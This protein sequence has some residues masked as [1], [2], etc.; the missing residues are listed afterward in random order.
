MLGTSWTRHPVR[1]F[2]KRHTPPTSPQ[3]AATVN[4][5]PRNRVRR[6]TILEKPIG[7]ISAPSLSHDRSSRLYKNFDRSKCL[8]SPPSPREG[9]GPG[10]TKRGLRPENLGHV[11]CAHEP[12]RLYGNCI[13]VKARFLNHVTPCSNFFL[14]SFSL[15]TGKNDER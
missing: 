11:N 1:L 13:E 2:K 6:L 9:V 14:L 7:F 15:P 4:P 12:K 3:A 10:A 5:I 8:T